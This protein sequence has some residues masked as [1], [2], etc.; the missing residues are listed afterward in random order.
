MAE[1]SNFLILYIYLPFLDSSKREK[2]LQEYTEALSMV[3]SILDDFPLHR[4]IIGGDFNTELKGRSPYDALLFDLMHKYKLSSCDSITN[5]VNG[6]QYTYRHNSLDHTKWNDH[7]MVSSTLLGSIKDSKILDDG[8][9]TSDHLPIIF[10]LPF[11][12][13]S[14]PCQDGDVSSQQPTSL[15]W[16]KCTEQQKLY[17]SRLDELL[18]CS[19]E[20][21]NICCNVHC[22]DQTCLERIQSE[23]DVIIS[24]LQ[25]ADKV[26]PRHKPGV[27]KSWWNENLTKIKQNKGIT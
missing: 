25:N 21:K 3:E 1:P 23:Y 7:F 13:G 10:D 5:G 14:V 9:N 17:T 24:C 2:S 12:T 6:V 4:I 19:P 16:E 22:Q 8:D 15:E 11:T 27:Q 26:L 20:T 18:W